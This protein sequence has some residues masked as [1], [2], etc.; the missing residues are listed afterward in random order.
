MSR[1]GENIYKRKDGRWEGCY[2]KERVDGK[3]KYGAVYAGSYREV[4]QK[5]DKIKHELGR[6]RQ[7]AG[8][9]EAVGYRKGMAFRSGSHAEKIFRQQ[10]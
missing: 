3:A 9:R 7:A 4:K 1:T 6:G 2:I 8:G 10:I 5:L